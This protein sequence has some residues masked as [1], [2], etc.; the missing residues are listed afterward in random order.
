MSVKEY[1]LAAINQISS[2]YLMYNMVAIVNIAY[3]KVAKRV[4]LKRT[5]YKKRILTM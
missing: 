2:G 5:L 4:D 3:L 1:K